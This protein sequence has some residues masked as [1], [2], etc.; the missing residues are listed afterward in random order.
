MQGYIL[1]NNG[2]FNS[3]FDTRFLYFEHM[4]LQ[5]FISNQATYSIGLPD[6]LPLKVTYVKNIFH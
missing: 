3:F 1:H 4:Q 6:Y 5:G 2:Y